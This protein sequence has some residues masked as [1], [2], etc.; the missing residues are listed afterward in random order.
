MENFEEAEKRITSAM[1]GI[2]NIIKSNDMNALCFL[3][4]SKVLSSP[5]R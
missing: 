2:S 4:K 5:L 3:Y 1:I